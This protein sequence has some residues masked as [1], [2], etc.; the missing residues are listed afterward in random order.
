MAEVAESTIPQQRLDG[1][2]FARTGPCPQVSKP[3]QEVVPDHIQSLIAKNGAVFC[4]GWSFGETFFG[5][6]GR[7]PPPR[8][9]ILLLRRRHSRIRNQKQK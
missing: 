2:G 8:L 1:V 7:Y 9:Q 4:R 5:F 6:G 3:S